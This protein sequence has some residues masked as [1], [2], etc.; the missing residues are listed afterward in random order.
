M[1][2]IFGILESS[3]NKQWYQDVAPTEEFFFL[4]A[5]IW[6]GSG[7]RTQKPLCAHQERFERGSER[8]HG[9]SR[10]RPN[11]EP[12]YL[13]NLIYIKIWQVRLLFFNEFQ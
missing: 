8:E 1:T 13:S 9:S 7:K 10:F 3:A 6:A 5:S 11:Y 12:I 4:V 2:D